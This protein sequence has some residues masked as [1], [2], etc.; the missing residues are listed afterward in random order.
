MPWKRLYNAIMKFPKRFK[1]A[2][3][4]RSLSYTDFERC[5]HCGRFTT[6]E[7]ALTARH[8]IVFEDK[9]YVGHATDVY[10]KH[11]KKDIHWAPSFIMHPHWVFWCW[12]CGYIVIMPALED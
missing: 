1:E 7:C 9:V 6:Q 11:Y 10:K 12:N 3:N 5:P 4:E 8:R 2:D